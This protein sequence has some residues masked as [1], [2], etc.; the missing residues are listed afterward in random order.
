MPAL[1]ELCEDGKLDEVRAELA[2]GGDVNNK[3]SNGSTALMFA[4][5]KG[6]NSIV[7]L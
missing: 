1:W 3:N 7:K 5:W 4:V 2:R 6:H